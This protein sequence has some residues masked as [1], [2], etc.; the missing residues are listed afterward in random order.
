MTTTP[1]NR[2]V[3]FA[4]LGTGMIADYHHQAIAANAG[5]GAWLV[6]VGHYCQGRFAEI[7]DRFGVP[8]LSGA[9]LLA[10]PGVD[11]VCISTPSGQHAE[12]AIAAAAAWPRYWPSMRPPVSGRKR[13]GTGYKTPQMGSD[14]LR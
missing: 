9:D 6:A 4:I 11:V 1:K 10:H 2:D 13:Q 8:C 7:G 5:L 12:Q 14:R 3:G